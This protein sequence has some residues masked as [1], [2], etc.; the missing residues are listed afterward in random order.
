MGK[1][2]IIGNAGES[3]VADY[4]KKQGFIVSA[5]NYHSRYGEIDVIAENNEQILFVEVK[6]RS[7]G[8]YARPYEYVNA[9]KMRKI[10]ITA[11][12]YLQHNGFGLQPRFDVAEVFKSDDGSFSLNYIENAFGAEAFENFR[13]SL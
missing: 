13:P 2:Q 12:I 10:F 9:R 3:L 11:G 6:T 5:R 4:L 8:S 1:T 7:D